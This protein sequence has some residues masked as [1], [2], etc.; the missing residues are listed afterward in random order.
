VKAKTASKKVHVQFGTATE[1]N[2]DYF[3]IERSQD[4]TSFTA[5][6]RIKGQ[7]N[8]SRITEYQYV[9]EAPLSG[10]N[11]YRIKQTDFDGKS[12]YSAVVKASAHSTDHT[13]EVYSDGH[14]VYLASPDEMRKVSLFDISGTRVFEKVVES[15]EFEIINEVNIP[16]WYVVRVE[17]SGQSFQ[18]L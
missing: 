7:G 14:V 3:T 15:N 16:G 5:L 17:T 6:D 18:K 9:D 10:N 4:G 1:I 11:F 8:S 2:N 13:I 12:S